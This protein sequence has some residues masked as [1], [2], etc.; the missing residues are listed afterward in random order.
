MTPWNLT[1]VA[2]LAA[3]LQRSG[4][5]IRAEEVLRTLN[6]SPAQYGAPRALATYYFLCG[7][8]DLAAEWAGKSVEQRDPGIPALLALAPFRSSA[9]WPALARAMNLVSD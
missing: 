5:T 8:M 1:A 9:R 6:N 3:V 2:V 4:K 7:E